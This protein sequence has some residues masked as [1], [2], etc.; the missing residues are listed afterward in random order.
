MKTRIVGI[1]L[2]ITA[3]SVAGAS[4]TTRQAAKAAPASGVEARLPGYLN[5]F[6]PFDPASKVSVEKAGA[7][8]PEKATGGNMPMPMHH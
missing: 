5:N 3:A 8:G 6:L 4:A 1:G 2:M 7:R